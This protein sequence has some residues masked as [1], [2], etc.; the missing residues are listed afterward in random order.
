[1][2]LHL[3]FSDRTGQY[4]DMNQMSHDRYKI[5]PGKSSLKKSLFI[6]VAFFEIRKSLGRDDTYLLL[7]NLTSIIHK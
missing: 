3:N 7:G 1:M 5:R 4:K 2:H 6:D